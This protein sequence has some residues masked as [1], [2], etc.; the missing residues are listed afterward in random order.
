M[1]IRYPAMLLRND[2]NFRR[3]FFPRLLRRLTIDT[4]NE[5]F[6]LVG[7]LRYFREFFRTRELGLMPNIV[8]ANRL[9][10][11]NSL[12]FIVGHNLFRERRLGVLRTY[13]LNA[14]NRRDFLLL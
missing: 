3:T 9:R 6:C 14:R 12:P 7:F 1:R 8:K 10:E 11:K 5:D 4:P 2:F 13:V